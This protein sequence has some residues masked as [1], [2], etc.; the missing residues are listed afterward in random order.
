MLLWLPKKKPNAAKKPHMARGSSDHFYTVT[1]T[2]M[3]MV[4]CT[5]QKIRKDNVVLKLSQYT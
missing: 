1:D 2:M 4:T 3:I 5:I